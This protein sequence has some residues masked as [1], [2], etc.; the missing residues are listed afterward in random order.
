MSAGYQGVAGEIA[1]HGPKNEVT[2]T[3][4]WFATSEIAYSNDAALED[5]QYIILVC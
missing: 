3:L 4:S 2:F 5:V 1:H